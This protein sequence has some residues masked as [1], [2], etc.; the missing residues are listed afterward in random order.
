MR[1]G[2]PDPNLAPKLR[3]GAVRW[4]WL[5]Q[6]LSDIKW[7]PVV[8]LEEPIRA[9]SAGYVLREES[10]F[11]SAGGNNRC[12]PLEPVYSPGPHSIY[13]PTAAAA[14]LGVGAKE[15][16]LL[17]HRDALFEVLACN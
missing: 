16:Y 3:C 10:P 5:L 1:Q 12:L 9:C 13:P 8:E 4:Q 11:G 14:D 2:I 15:I 6:G 7:P 17:R